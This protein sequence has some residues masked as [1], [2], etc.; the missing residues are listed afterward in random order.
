VA[1]LHYSEDTLDHV[2]DQDECVLARFLFLM[3]TYAGIGFDLSRDGDSIWLFEGG[4]APYILRDSGDG[5]SYTFVGECYVA[6]IMDG[7]LMTPGFR[8][9]FSPI[10]LV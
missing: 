4:R 8:E 1:L 7:E 6:G 10:E 3:D 2:L 5:H 9:G